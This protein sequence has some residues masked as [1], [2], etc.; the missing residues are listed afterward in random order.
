MLTVIMP[1]YNTEMELFKRACYSVLGQTK[2]CLLMVVDDCSNE[3]LS[4]QYADFC[5]AHN[6]GYHRL[7]INGGPGAARQYGIDFGYINAEWIAFL[8][9]DD[10]LLPTFCEVLTKEGNQHNA[11]MVISKI[12]QQGKDRTQDT[13]IEIDECATWLHGKIFRRK[14]L[15]DNG[16]KFHP[17]LRYNEDVYFEIC[18][19][20][21]TKNVAAVYKEFYIW[22]YNKNSLTHNK[23][24]KEIVKEHTIDYLFANI[25]ALSFLLDKEALPFDFGTIV[26]QI[27][28]AYQ[29][30]LVNGRN[31]SAIDDYIGIK[32]KNFNIDAQSADFY[33]H[34]LA[35]SKT[36][37]E[38]VIFRQ[39]LADWLIHFQEVINNGSNND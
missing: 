35:V 32:I 3:D 15:K 38:G 14:F 7:T 37:Y 6:I 1:V 21:M 4:F 12:V 17:F 29:Y 23:P 25:D 2:H 10:I 9:S 19:S 13:F 34:M 8:D 30:E 24:H 39:S 18:C 22:S 11:D 27:Y 33:N 20:K 31:M 26:G 36:N 5:A 16:I 28:N